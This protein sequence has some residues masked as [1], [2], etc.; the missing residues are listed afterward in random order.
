MKFMHQG[1]AAPMEHL[2]TNGCLPYYRAPH[3]Y[4]CIPYR[5][6]ENRNR[7]GRE[8]ALSL[9]FEEWFFDIRSDILTDGMLMSSRG[10]DVFQRT[11]LEAFTPSHRNQELAGL[12]PCDLLR[13]HSDG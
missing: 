7:V 11:F 3:I 8:E 4:I 1:V 13:D 6:V 5:L 2:Y 12:R 10:G 9:D